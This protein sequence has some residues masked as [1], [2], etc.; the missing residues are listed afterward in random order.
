[1]SYRDE[2]A[3]SEIEWR[4]A[5]RYRGTV[6]AYGGPAF[7]GGDR[8]ACERIL[9]SVD[10]RRLAYLWIDATFVKTRQ[11]GRIVSVAVIIAVGVNTDG[12]R[13]LLGLAV[14][15]IKNSR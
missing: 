5:L 10:R 13:E 8:R 2:R 7:G 6:T 11:L 3:D 15:S 12:T 14:W 9:E 4:A 1:M